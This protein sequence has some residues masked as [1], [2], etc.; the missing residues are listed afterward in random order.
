MARLIIAVVVGL[1]LATG[2][3]VLAVRALAPVSDGH[4][5]QAT[6]YQYGIR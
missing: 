4:P 2:A 6:L 3:S 5:T 1:V